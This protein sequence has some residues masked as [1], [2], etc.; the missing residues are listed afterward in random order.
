MANP[1]G[2]NGGKTSTAAETKKRESGGGGG[3]GG[4][5][6]R[7]RSHPN[8]EGGEI[9]NNNDNNTG[10]GGESN[11][12]D[13]KHQHHQHRRHRHRH[14]H[15]PKSTS[16]TN[17]NNTA[18]DTDGAQD[19]DKLKLL[20]EFI[21]YVGLG[22]AAR[23]NMVRSI[24]CAAD[25]EELVG[26]DD[27]GNTLLI[28]A[29][30]YRRKALVPLILARSGGAIDLD[31][32][33]SEGACALHFACYKDSICVE[34][35]FLLL[36]RGAKPEVVEN[37]H[38]CTPLHYAAGA[39]DVDLC[40]RLIEKGARVNT[41]DFYQFTAVDYAKQS[42]AT[43]C[44]AYLEEVSTPGATTAA[45]VKSSPGRGGLVTISGVEV[46]SGLLRDD[47]FD[48]VDDDFRP[49]G[50]AAKATVGGGGENAAALGRQPSSGS[51]NF[52][53]G[54]E[55]S[56]GGEGYW[57]RQGDPESGLA[58]YLNEKTGESMWEK[59]LLVQ[60]Q[61]LH[62]DLNE[63]EPSPQ[64]A[65]WL[66]QQTQ[67][68]RL[69]AFLG[70]HDPLKI[71][72]ADDMLKRR[73]GDEEALFAE[74]VKQY[75]A[76]EEPDFAALVEG[77][78]RG[79]RDHKIASPAPAATASDASI[80]ATSRPS[81]PTTAPGATAK[82]EALETLTA[83]LNRGVSVAAAVGSTKP[84]GG[85]GG[86]GGGGRPPTAPAQRPGLRTGARTSTAML[87]MTRSAK[88]LLGTSSLIPTAPAQLSPEDL[89]NLQ[90]QAQKRLDD[91][92]AAHEERL[93]AERKLHRDKAAEGEGAIARMEHD[94]KEASAEEERL[95]AK[96]EEQKQLA[97][98][99]E[100]QLQEKLASQSGKVKALSEEAAALRSEL[101]AAVEETQA[102][103]DVVDREQSGAAS[104]AE[105]SR[106]DM[107][108]KAK[109]ESDLVH[110]CQASVAAAKS[111][112][113]RARREFAARRQVEQQNI[114]DRL[115]GQLSL[116][117]KEL[118]AAKSKAAVDISRAQ[119]DAAAATSKAKATTALV[120]DVSAQRE[121][122]R[123]ELEKAE[124]TAKWN[125]LLQGLVLSESERRKKLH[126]KMEDLKGKIRVYVRVRP[127]ST[128]E[129]AR[130][131][132]EAVTG[133]G[134]TTIAV[135]DPRVKE[136]KTFDFDQVWSGT[137]EQ[138][139][140]QV[141]IF[142][143]TGYL[144]TSTVDGYNV[145]IFAYGQTGSGKTY[146]MFGAGGIGGGI[147]AT[148][149]VCDGTA[150]VT[151]RAVLELFRVLKE[152]EGQYEYSVKVSMF[153][154]YRDGLRDLLAK[155][156]SHTKLVIKLAE[157]S[158][159]GLVVVEGGV[160]RDANDIK[161][162]IDVIQV[163]A[164]GRTVSS[165]QMN[166]DSSRSHLLCSIVVTST[167]RRTGSSLRGK[168]T[169][170]DLA[171]SERVGKSGASGDQLKEAQSI[172]KS[173][174]ALG[175]VIGALT[176]GVKHIPY[177]NH[178]LTMMM[179]DSLGGNSK[180]LMFVCASPADYNASETINALQFA[181]RCKSVTNSAG[182]G[183]GGAAA[184]AQVQA[185]RRELQKLKGGD[186]GGNEAAKKPTQ[187]ARPS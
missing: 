54:G 174:S 77:A 149:G 141:N 106:R 29:C 23:D 71:M 18:S 152:R 45:T 158:G 116:L 43:V 123:R 25:A 41:W 44:V 135:Q 78:A 186:G 133:Q 134:T 5:T 82:E 20:I 72:Q 7:K 83:T 146:T 128:K 130:G 129:K 107:E 156:G 70:R 10:T 168:L 172:N 12:H 51:D 120:V 39:G 139:N 109:E 148:A 57:G 121:K 26:T 99:L 143:D 65:Q 167:N 91:A 60:A 69:V 17:D 52:S 40:K 147:D 62:D 165:T 67:R 13:R 104:A 163:G 68:A 22:D 94:L 53:V 136:E 153:E 80:A 27:Y 86:G 127:F 76:E 140:N 161:T 126:N 95:R 14:R 98:S 118:A 159:T 102:L 59:D 176:T 31:A 34:T 49:R 19:E 55:D 90:E 110:E 75:S 87:R 28:L 97:A 138:G 157:H 125:T 9:N 171:G 42:G 144:V 85:G 169:L 184:A 178:A 154:L 21:P 1:E 137:E 103:S 100:G 112:A 166:S 113:E 81:S 50:R 177:R 48:T 89:K 74:L 180:T 79:F 170:V 150:G 142:K 132:T 88:D 2:G 32:V 122:M 4:S 73:L 47:S 182:P 119:S 114:L 131:C 15:G 36:E 33:N 101:K 105:S 37:T 11:G 64:L 117:Q 164:E 24:L 84:G 92:K 115:R 151:P 155:K 38:G 93:E 46:P 16:G 185:L 66:R 187:L 179:S 145:C 6:R 30:Q 96:I 108:T 63:E 56:G 111:D 160:E 162:M 181:A 175:D 35:A 58:Y 8:T 3:G 183:G 124:L 61:A 173:L